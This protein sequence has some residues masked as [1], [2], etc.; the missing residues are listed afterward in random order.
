MI[1][2]TLVYNSCLAARTSNFKNSWSSLSLAQEIFRAKTV[3]RWRYFVKKK[4]FESLKFILQTLN[5]EWIL[6]C[7]AYSNKQN[8][9]EGPE[10]FFHGFGQT[11]NLSEWTYHFLRFGKTIRNQFPD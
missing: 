2:H 9:R 4:R 3:G 8:I 1:G 7:Q 6:M 10:F 11:F 5:V